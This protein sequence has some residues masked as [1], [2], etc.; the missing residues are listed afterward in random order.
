MITL[1]QKIFGSA[2][3]SNATAK[4]RLHFVLVQDRTGLSSDE[5]SSFKEALVAVIEKYFEIEKDGFDISYKREN[6]ETAL[7]INSPVIV[8]KARSRKIE[9]KSTKKDAAADQE[10]TEES[11]DSA[12]AV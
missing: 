11:S 4:S 1:W 2:V 10:S 12:P 5:M 8:R 3:N 9:V 6:D 7:V